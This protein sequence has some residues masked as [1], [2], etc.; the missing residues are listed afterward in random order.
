MADKQQYIYDETTEAKADIVLQALGQKLLQSELYEIQAFEKSV[1]NIST[2]NEVDVKLNKILSDYKTREKI[3]RRKCF[4]KKYA[5]VC[6][7]FFVV[8][9][10]SGFFAINN[11]E[12][13]K[14]KFQSLFTEEHSNHVELNASEESNV[15]VYD[16]FEI[17]NIWFPSYLP[18]GFSPYKKASIT[19]STIILFENK[20]QCKIQFIQQP[21]TEIT[22]TVNNEGDAYGV[23]TILTENDAYFTSTN[24][25]TDLVWLQNDMMMELHSELSLDELIRIARSVE[26]YK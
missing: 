8:L 6:A 14:F 23:T 18:D 4:I 16:D 19:N 9:F 7:L 10:I 11:V 15:T 17:K 13:F 22:Y 24:G 2:P 12:A 20:D 1:A 5:R 25:Q 3:T 21:A 26:F